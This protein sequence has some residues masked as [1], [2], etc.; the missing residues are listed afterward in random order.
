[1]VSFGMAWLKTESIQ[2]VR[3]VTCVTSRRSASWRHSVIVA[4]DCVV[5]SASAS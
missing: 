5:R 3:D 1:M 2:R 4:M